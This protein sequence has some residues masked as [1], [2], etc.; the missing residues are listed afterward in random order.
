MLYIITHSSAREPKFLMLTFL[1][2]S[3]IRPSSC[4]R[5]ITVLLF[6]TSEQYFCLVPTAADC[7]GCLPSMLQIRFFDAVTVSVIRWILWA[8]EIDVTH[9]YCFCSISIF[10][11]ASLPLAFSDNYLC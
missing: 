9:H 6:V 10:S 4:L 3:L 8:E 2:R 1:D 7:F 5:L 11:S